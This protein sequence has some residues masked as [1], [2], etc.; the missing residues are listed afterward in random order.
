MR[1]TS[2]WGLKGMR[3]VAIAGLDTQSV[4]DVKLEENVISFHLQILADKYTGEKERANPNDMRHLNA[5]FSPEKEELFT[6]FSPLPAMLARLNTLGQLTADYELKDD[7]QVAPMICKNA[8]NRTTTSA[9]TA[10]DISKTGSTFLDKI[11]AVKKI[12]DAT[13]AEKPETDELEKCWKHEIIGNHGA[14]YGT[15][16][17]MIF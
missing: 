9:T 12:K 6:V 7:R 11:F 1:L 16:C 13:N 17:R 4:R 10:E 3:N 15:L 8:A 14:R 5:S 2:P